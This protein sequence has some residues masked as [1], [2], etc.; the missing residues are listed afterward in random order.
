MAV[1]FTGQRTGFASLQ[2]IAN[3]RDRNWVKDYLQT[4][5]E[6]EARDRTLCKGIKLDPRPY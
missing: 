2:E 5:V 1:S 4:N 6:V 3:S